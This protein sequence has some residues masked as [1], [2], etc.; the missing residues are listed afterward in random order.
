MLSD[1]TCWFLAADFDKDAW[2]DDA[3]ALLE[4]CRANGVAAALERSRSGNGGHV[5]IF[6]DE[7]V[8]ARIARQMGAALITE[9][10]ESGPRSASTS[11]DRFFPN[12]DT[13]P[14]G[15]FGNLIALP[16]QRRARENGNSV[17]VDEDLQPYDDQWAFLSTVAAESGGA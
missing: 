9:T 1:E 3:A 2:A 15:G 8:P 5:W 4:T 10:M 13:M 16:L 11:Y 12:Q 6:F 7:P 17:F 14:L